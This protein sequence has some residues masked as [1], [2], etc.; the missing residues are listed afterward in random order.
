[1]SPRL[2][3]PLLQPSTMWESPSHGLVS[4]V[5]LFDVG[6]SCFH[7]SAR[8]VHGTDSFLVE[9]IPAREPPVPSSL[10]QGFKHTGKSSLPAVGSLLDKSAGL[11][12]KAWLSWNVARSRVVCGASLEPCQSSEC[13]GVFTMKKSIYNIEGSFNSSGNLEPQLG[14]KVAG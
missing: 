14:A 12:G 11:E 2:D 4:L 10:E 5:T 13:R 7:P 1:M 3:W 9:L 6:S 8:V